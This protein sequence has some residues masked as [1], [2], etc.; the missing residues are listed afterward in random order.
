MQL[1]LLAPLLLAPTAVLAFVLPSSSRSAFLVRHSKAAALQVV[2]Y[3]PDGD[4]EEDGSY[5]YA[6]NNDKIDDNANPNSWMYE[7]AV[8]V[9]ESPQLLDLQQQQ[10]LYNNNDALAQQLTLG[11]QDALARLS[12]AYCPL[13][14]QGLH[15]ADIDSVSVLEMDGTHVDIQAVVCATEGCLTI[16]VP[17]SFPQ[18]CEL[19]NQEECILHQI[20]LLDQSAGDFLLLQQQ[21][22]MKGEGHED[23]ERARQELLCATNLDYPSWWQPPL[24]LLE[25]CQSVRQLLNQNDFQ[26]ELQ[27]LAIASLGTSI[28]LGPP[29][30]NYDDVEEAAMVDVCPS[31]LFLR[32]RLS[33]GSLV[34]LPLPFDG[35]TAS[36][37]EEENNL[38][39]K[40]LR[41][42]FGA[43]STMPE[44]QQ[45]QRVTEPLLT[46]EKAKEQVMGEINDVLVK[47]KA[48]RR[49]EEHV[50]EHEEEYD[51]IMQPSTKWSSSSQFK[52]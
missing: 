9:E 25:E 7:D 35:G 15:L 26:S 30:N 41:T 33:D 6:Y 18:E 10:Q 21:Q 50:D 45:Q 14:A 27:T 12:V 44:E 36:I 13:D 49:S 28:S 52:K 4:S 2:V 24:G 42:V 38:R 39:A 22:Q 29:R 32:A 16:K 31:G 8:V 46:N 34:D 37:N 19:E 48:A 3:Y 1:L 23:D 47:E 5:Q 11:R 40:V 20:E 17:I 43:K 51:P